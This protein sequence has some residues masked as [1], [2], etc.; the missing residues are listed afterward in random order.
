MFRRSMILLSAAGLLALL[1]VAVPA[2]FAQSSSGEIDG[3]VFDESGGAL[4][5]V[6]VTAIDTATGRQRVVI[7]AADG[8]FRIP[9][10]PIGSYDVKAELTGFQSVNVEGVVVRVASSSSITI[11]LKLAE[12]QEV[13]TVSADVPLV[14][15]SPSIGTVVTEKELESLPLNGR[16]FASLGTLAPGTTLGVNPDPTKVGKLTIGLNGGS[17]RN[18]NFLVDGGDNT[19]DTIGGQLQNFSLESVAEFSIQ[20]QQYKA[21]YGRTTGGVL[22]VVTKSGTNEIDGSIFGFFRDDSLNSKTETQERTGADKPPFER[23]QFGFSVGGPIVRDKAHF[24]LT[25]ERFD[26]EAPFTIASGGIFPELDGRSFPRTTQD[27]LITAKLTSDL[28]AKELLQVR[29]AYQKT[30]DV[31]G[32][33]TTVGPESVGD[34]NNEFQTALL[35]YNRLL[36]SDSF[37]E[38]VVQYSEFEN[39]ILPVT[40]AP[41]EYFPSGFQTGQNVNSPQ[42]TTQEK[43]QVKDDFSFSKV[44]GGS[45]HDFKAGVEFIDEGTLGGFFAP[46]AAGQ[47]SRAADDRNAPITQIIFLS[48]DFAFSTPNDQWRA[49][50]QDDWY[51][52]DRLTVNLG[53]RYDY[54]DILKL[55]Q[56]TNALWQTLRNQTQFNEFYLQDFKQGDG[57]RVL[58]ADDDDFAPRVGFTWDVGGDGRRL[59]RGGWGLFYDFPYSNATVLFPAAAVLSTFGISYLHTDSNGIRNPDGT[60]FNIGDPLPPNQ[61]PGGAGIAINEVASPTLQTPYSTQ[62]SLGYSHQINSTWGVNVEAVSIRY[63]SLPFRFRANPRF[64]SNGDGVVDNNDTRRFPA[65]GNFRLWYGKGSADYDALNLSVRGRSGKLEFQGFYTL[66]EAEGNI[67]GGADE[68][69]LTATEHQPDL[70]GARDVSVDPLNPL[71]SKCFGPLNTDARHRITLSGVYQLPYGIQLSGVFRFRSALPYTEHAGV[72]LNGDSFNLDLPPDV[73]HVNSRRGASLSQLD[74]RVSKIFDLGGD[75]SI[76]VIGEVFNL[77]DDENPVRFVGNRSASN[78]GQPTTFAGDPN[79]GEQRLAQLGVRLRF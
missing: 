77:L 39:L 31:Y 46:G 54:T 69:R 62:A 42:S 71:C 21:E 72:D 75:L 41:T 47:F 2:A 40:D 55:D 59:L 9:G 24:F 28:S 44:I 34:L 32:A 4:P 15:N 7:T 56:S 12:V 17:G 67:L 5:G 51:V 14:R 26:Q 22:T 45:R 49:Y 43:F 68:F 13:I 70:G 52:N 60:F 11:T 30:E 16:Q 64:D 79:Q 1:L 66:S 18:V 76:E 6:T 61:L 65:F 8:S 73:P 57:G 36:G 74:V 33:A 20:T 10:L 3:R 37:N 63:N 23:Q 48:G 35:G 27:D 25:A 38:V 58:D 78:F 29:Y 53:I 50:F 19:D